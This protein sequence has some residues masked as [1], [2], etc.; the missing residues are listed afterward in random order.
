MPKGVEHINEAAGNT[1]TDVVKI[2]MMPKGVEHN[3]G[4]RYYGA[5]LREDSNDAE[6][7]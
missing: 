3:C 1:L 5:S 7:R 2:P 4:R 6:R